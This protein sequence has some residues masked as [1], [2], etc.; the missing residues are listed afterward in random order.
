M[1]TV[2]KRRK[3]KHEGRL[4]DRIDEC[5]KGGQYK[6]D[7]SHLSLPDLPLEISVV[8]R[9]TVFLAYGNNITTISSISN[10]R[11]LTTLDV[12]RNKLTSLDDVK[13]SHLINLRV[14]D[15]SRNEITS[16]PLDICKLPVLDT[17]ICHRNLIVSCYM[18][19]I[20]FVLMVVHIVE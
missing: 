19:V 12:S 1:Q 10:F 18:D 20:C 4:M 14:M 5:E 15:I 8:S 17:L 3:G 16:L 2:E 7:I 13:L 11:N 9:V 6:L